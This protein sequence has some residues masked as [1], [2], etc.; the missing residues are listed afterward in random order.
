[1]DQVG[2]LKKKPLKDPA[3]KDR[4]VSEI[5]RYGHEIIKVKSMELLGNNPVNMYSFFE[6]TKSSEQINDDLVGLTGR[7]LYYI[8]KI[9][10]QGG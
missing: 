5:S 8:S 6:I 4:M 7:T 1:L 3:P 9:P 10:S 2:K